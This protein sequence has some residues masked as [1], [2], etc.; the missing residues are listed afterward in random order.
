M[1]VEIGVLG[2][3]YL[4]R[5]LLFGCLLFCLILYPV[6]SFA[7]TSY[8]VRFRQCHNERVSSESVLVPPRDR[9]A[10]KVWKKDPMHANKSCQ[11]PKI[12]GAQNYSLLTKGVLSSRKFKMR[13]LFER[14]FYVLQIFV[15]KPQRFDPVGSYL[16]TEKKS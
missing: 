14:I 5:F 15:L 3:G 10:P 6:A 8:C 16:S 9:T 12:S 2:Q 4:C 1:P 13:W 7:A 11:L